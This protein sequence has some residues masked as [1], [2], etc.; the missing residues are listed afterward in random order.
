MVTCN[1]YIIVNCVIDK[2][3]TTIL[4]GIMLFR[5]IIELHFKNSGHIL[6]FCRYKKSMKGN[7]L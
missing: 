2:I 3:F 5:N 4:R 1:K 6:M 7:T